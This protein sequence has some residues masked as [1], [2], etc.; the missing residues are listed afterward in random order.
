MTP[1]DK[2][3]ARRKGLYLYRTTQNRNTQR[4][5]IQASSEIRAHDS[6]NQVEDLRLRPRNHRDRPPSNRDH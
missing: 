6:S 1:L 2:C 5:N 4:K 3:S